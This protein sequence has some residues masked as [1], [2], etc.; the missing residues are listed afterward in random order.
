MNATTQNPIAAA[1]EGQEILVLDGGLA[2]ALEARGFDLDDEL[3]SARV[4]LEAPDAIRQVHLDFLAAGAD[5]ITTA[6]YQASLSGFRKRGLSDADGAELLRL[7]VRLAIEARDEFWSEAA[8]R[9]DRRRPLVAASIGPYGAYLADGSEYTGRYG[10]GDDALYGFHRDRWRILAGSEADLLA[11]ETIP[12]GQEAAVLQRLLRE[13]AGRWAWLSFSCRDG[14]HLCDGSRLVEVAR[15]CDAE[16][17]VAA[18]GINCTSPGFIAPLIAEARRG[19]GKPIIVYPNSGERYDLVGKR[20]IG[21]AA[22]LDWG[23]ASLEWA[24]LGAAAIGGCCRVGPREIARIRRRC[25]RR[26]NP[27]RNSITTV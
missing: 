17:A 18:V 16:P 15:K 7:S 12:S 14:A 10:I 1:A 23:E 25:Q 11:C 2:T 6:S 20:W 8:N 26:Q 21:G 19:T 5:C 13:T 4:L 3:W 9:R 22:E 24:R 27:G